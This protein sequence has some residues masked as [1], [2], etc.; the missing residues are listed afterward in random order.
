MEQWE[1][2]RQ[3]RRAV[4]FAGFVGVLLSIAE[5]DVQYISIDRASGLLTPTGGY[6]NSTRT[7]EA[8]DRNDACR[9]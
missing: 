3:E 7:E 1:P 4:E 8:T 9:R 6:E 2:D 5:Y